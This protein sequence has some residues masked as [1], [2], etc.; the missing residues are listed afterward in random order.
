MTW[1]FGPKSRDNPPIYVQ[2]LKYIGQI[3]RWL[4]RAGP[5]SDH[6]QNAPASKPG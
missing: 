1:S 5:K 4:I 2:Q 3:S 6:F